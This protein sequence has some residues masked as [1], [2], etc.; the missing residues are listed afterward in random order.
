MMVPYC[1]AAGVPWRRSGRLPQYQ[2]AVVPGCRGAT[3]TSK[4]PWCHDTMQL[5]YHCA[6]WHGARHSIIM[7]WWCHSA[8]VLHGAMLPQCHAG[9]GTVQCRHTAMLPCYHCA[10]CH[11]VLVPPFH[12]SMLQHV[13]VLQWWPS[14][15]VPQCC[16]AMMLPWCHVA[17]IVQC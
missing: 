17:I 3:L 9:P 8:M 1:H 13:A 15:M 10:M 11:C 12:A 5:C 2:G 16:I 7:P 14:A 6:T 4:V